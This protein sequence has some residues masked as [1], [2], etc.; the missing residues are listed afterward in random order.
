MDPYG[1][2]GSGR[3]GVAA[4]VAVLQ[5]AVDHVLQEAKQKALARV[6]GLPPFIESDTFVG[7]KRGYYFGTG[8]QGVGWV[9]SAA[10]EAAIAVHPQQHTPAVPVCRHRRPAA[11]HS[12][13]YPTGS[14]L[15]VVTAATG[16][17]AGGTRQAH[18][19]GTEALLPPSPGTTV[20]PSSQT[21]RPMRMRG[22]APGRLGA[23]RSRSWTQSSC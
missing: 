5:A 12:C 6:T 23:P 22:R 20:M 19:C 17:A 16:G 3:G 2:H 7:P 9:P 10:A 11:S 14:L 15:C 18:A 13:T 4:P 8:E 21:P 1:N